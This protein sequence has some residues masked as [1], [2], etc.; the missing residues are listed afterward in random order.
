MNDVVRRQHHPQLAFTLGLLARGWAGRSTARAPLGHVA[1]RLA[2]AAVLTVTGD[3]VVGRSW[4]A[5]EGVGGAGADRGGYRRR[6]AWPVWCRHSGRHRDGPG[7]VGSQRW[8]LLR[9]AVPG[10]SYFQ[11]EDREE[12]SEDEASRDTT[13]GVWSRSGAGE[14]CG[15]T[16]GRWF[17][18]IQLRTAS[19]TSVRSSC[20]Q[21]RASCSAASWLRHQRVRSRKVSRWTR[22]R[23]KSFSP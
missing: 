12:Q 15:D 13:R 21:R 6:R 4:C 2:A 20:P 19:C 14:G 7:V 17:A 10:T 5:C 11:A 23:A 3:C 9:S 22:S 18:N 1:M 16:Q 8:E